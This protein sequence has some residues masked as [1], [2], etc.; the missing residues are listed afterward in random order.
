MSTLDVLKLTPLPTHLMT[1][2]QA[3]YQ[4]HD[5]GH[6]IDPAAFTRV[7]VMVGTSEMKVDAKLLATYPH[8][9][10]VCVV[11]ERFDQVDME[12]LKAR[13]IS[14]TYTPGLTDD[15]VADLAMGLVLSVV[16]KIPEAHRFVRNA[17]WVDGPFALTRQVTGIRMGLMGDKALMMEIAK[18]AQGFKMMLNYHQREEDHEFSLRTPIRWW[19]DLHAMAKEVD[20]LV[21]CAS[22]EKSNQA[23]GNHP[24]QGAMVNAS[25]IEA[26][27]AQAYVINVGDPHM[28][29]Q[30]ALLQALQQKKLAGAAL[31]VFV[32]EPK[33]SAEW[34]NLQNAV[35]TPHMGAST[36]GAQK[37]MAAMALTHLEE[38]QK[39]QAA[40]DCGH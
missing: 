14:L 5:H 31:D 28:L 40:L 36:E 10:R 23:K 17:D 25:V 26:L 16:R 11:G 9:R 7:S 15:D 38:F 13:S 39:H 1:A 37:A 8:V 27:G 20:V 19:A 29:D 3:R 21:L 24:E 22:A 18:R 2:L 32:E 33:V 35:L 4:V 6:L 30:A 34:R 12:A